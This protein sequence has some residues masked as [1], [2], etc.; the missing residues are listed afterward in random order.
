M[1][2]D[3]IEKR[4]SELGLSSFD[5]SRQAGLDR[6][7]LYDLIAG[8][9]DRIQPKNLKRIATVLRCSPGYLTGA[10]DQPHNVSADQSPPWVSDPPTWE[11]DAE[12]G[13]I[14]DTAFRK[15]KAIYPSDKRK[16]HRFNNWEKIF[17]WCQDRS[18]S[19][20]GIIPG[21]L[22]TAIKIEAFRRELRDF[23]DGDIVVVKHSIESSGGLYAIACRRV[24]A[25]DNG[26]IFT[27]ENAEDH[28]VFNDKQSGVEVIGVVA[29][30]KYELI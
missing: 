30:I 23:N 17:F 20:A 25:S 8:R 29:S 9:K 15:S 11:D 14:D 27:H 13:I 6:T 21:A 18:M 3:R 7:F 16:R 28:P 1:L 12:I 4:L 2:K 24:V 26:F 5:A 22:V 10:E 19:R